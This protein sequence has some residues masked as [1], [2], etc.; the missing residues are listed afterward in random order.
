[1]GPKTGLDALQQRK[2]PCLAGNRIPVM[3]PIARSYTELSPLV[4]TLGKEFGK[5]LKKLN[6]IKLC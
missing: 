3:H 6:R 4:Y 2:I 1:M 5:I